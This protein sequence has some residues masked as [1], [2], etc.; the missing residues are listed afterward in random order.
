MPAIMPAAALFRRPQPKINGNTLSSNAAS[1]ESLLYTDIPSSMNPHIY[2][3][4]NHFAPIVFRSSSRK[5]FP[6]NGDR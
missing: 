4:S 5:S 2:S 6:N 1:T 3:C